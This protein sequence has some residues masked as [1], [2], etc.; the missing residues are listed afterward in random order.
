MTKGPAGPESKNDCAG[1]GQQSGAL[2]I[3][4]SGE[5]L[6]AYREQ[7]KVK[8]SLCFIKHRSMEAYGSVEV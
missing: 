1:E 2:V 3:A 7:V 6:T 8:S 5:E 4:G